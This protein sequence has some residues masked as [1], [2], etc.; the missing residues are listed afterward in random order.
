MSGSLALVTQVPKP[1]VPW[2]LA[3]WVILAPSIPEY[4]MSNDM[5][6]L[7]LINWSDATE[8][9]VSCVNQHNISHIVQKVRWCGRVALDACLDQNY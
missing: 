7:N 8:L 4:E 3:L 5:C 9:K 2:L 6:L 1:V